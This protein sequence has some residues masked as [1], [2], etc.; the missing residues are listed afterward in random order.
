MFQFRPQTVLTPIYQ[1][2][3]LIIGQLLQ[4]KYTNI[5][6]PGK[7]DYKFAVTLKTA[8][9]LIANICRENQR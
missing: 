5:T 4:Q 2:S 3:P 1:S 7:F 6:Y 8:S 9:T